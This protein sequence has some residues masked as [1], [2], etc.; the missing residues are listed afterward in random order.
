MPV[1][2]HLHSIPA[3]FCLAMS[4]IETLID[5]AN[6]DHCPTSIL[7]YCA[8]AMC[9]VLIRVD[10]VPPVKVK[11]FLFLVTSLWAIFIK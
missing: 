4:Y 3:E 7:L 10:L 9:K 8:E 5:V 11:C 6:T 1:Q 2:V